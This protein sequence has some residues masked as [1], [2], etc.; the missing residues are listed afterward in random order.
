MSE[1][2][3]QLGVGPGGTVKVLRNNTRINA[4][5]RGDTVKVLRNN[6]RIIASTGAGKVKVLR[7]NARIIAST[8]G[9]IVKLPG[10]ILELMFQLGV[11]QRKY[12]EECQ[13]YCFN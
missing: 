2:L 5:T 3:I 4:S 8:R 13:N 6:T 9:G 7:N 1:L 11:A 10:T 12:Q